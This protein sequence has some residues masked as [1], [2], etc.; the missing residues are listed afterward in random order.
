M[1]E[2]TLLKI[3]LICSLVGLI[4]LYFISSKIEIKDYKPGSLNKNVGDNVK[5]NG[6]VTKITDRGDVIFIDVSQ[7]TPVAVVLFSN[8]DNIK[9]KSGDN[10]EVIGEVQE[11]NGKTEIIAEKIRVVR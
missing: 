10:I 9:L 1:K 7:Q 8:D 2:S 6:L 11:Y 3:A 4:A 5:L